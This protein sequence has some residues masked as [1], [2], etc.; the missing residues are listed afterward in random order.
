MLVVC[1][2]L[3]NDLEPRNWRGFPMKDCGKNWAKMPRFNLYIP[4]TTYFFFG[5]GFTL[6]AGRFFGLESFTYMDIY[7]YIYIYIYIFIE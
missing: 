2:C 1:S 4:G 3:K 7:I 6:T 5:L